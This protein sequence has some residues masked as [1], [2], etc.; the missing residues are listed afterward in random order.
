MPDEASTY[1]VPARWRTQWHVR[2][3]GFHGLSVQWASEQ[4]RVERLVVCHLGGGCSV[5]AVFGAARSTH[6]GLQPARGC[7]RWHALGLARPGSDR[8]PVAP[9]RRN[10][11]TRSSRRW[12]ATP[13]FSGC[14]G[15]RLEW[16]TSSAR[17]SPPREA[18]ARGLLLRHRGRD[19][20]DGGGA[21]RAGRD[22]LQRR[23]GGGIRAR[24]SER[25]RTP[26][27][28]RRRLV[29]RLNAEATADAE[30]R[31]QDS[32]GCGSSSCGRARTSSPHAR[33]GPCSQ[34]GPSRST[35]PG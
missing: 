4:V 18:G 6:D 14:R 24:A 10:P 3:Y 29:E 2:R 23:R 1:A 25:V 35:S 13:D 34:R 15:S 17:Q 9:R 21:R 31:R 27:V 28:P 8:L 5:S 16:R 30:S 12:S 26:R 22:R 19:R 20:S 11:S 33:C 32:A 7:A